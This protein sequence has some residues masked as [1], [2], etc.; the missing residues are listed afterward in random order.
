MSNMKSI[1]EALVAHVRQYITEQVEKLTQRADAHS[2]R[3][4]Q[5]F[6]K[7][8]DLEERIAAIPS[9]A[10][11]EKGLPGD[12]GEKG[13]HGRDGK[14][15]RDGLVGQM[16]ERGLQG[17]RGE[18]G[19]PGPA[20]A[21]G[22]QGPPGPA[23]EKGMDGRAGIDGADGERGP[24]GEKGMDGRSVTLE[25]IQPL[26]ESVIARAQLE[27]ERRAQDVIQ[28]AIDR[29]PMP[30]DGLPGK[31]GR[32]GMDGQKGLDGKD[33]R[34]AF[35]L[36]DLF[37]EHDGER[38][39]TVGFRRGEEVVSKTITVPALIDRGVYGIG[40]AY[41]KGDGVTYGGDFWIA[42][43]DAPQGE[44]PGSSDAW[45]LAVRKGRDGRRGE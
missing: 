23:G 41:E 38:T 17:E 5:L 27:I 2:R 1:G 13:E 42:T 16:G 33:G 26:L 25:D 9:G 44:K 22:P 28:R 10:Q 3:I 43:R 32:D 4:E 7:A 31:D 12:R 36:A 34:D 14:D 39:F 6:D 45:R 37:I 35:D 20:G 21:A 8:T 18:R 30:K 40:K 11:G 19:E 15:G 29:I 24:A